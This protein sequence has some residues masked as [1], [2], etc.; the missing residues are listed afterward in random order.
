VA[1]FTVTEPPIEKLTPGAPELVRKTVAGASVVNVSVWDESL[2]FTK[3][4]FGALMR[5]VCWF[6]PWT[7]YWATTVAPEQMTL[8]LAQLSTPARDKET[9]ALLHTPGPNVTVP[10]SRSWSFD[11]TS[12]LML[13]ADTEAI[14][15]AV[16]A[17]APVQHMQTSVPRIRA[18]IPSGI[19]KLWSFPTN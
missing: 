6:D 12:G 10:R 13:F 4:T 7:L 17:G 1:E 14:T 5:T 3:V 15:V 18:K 2:W 8:A 9:V 11:S 16:C 19:R